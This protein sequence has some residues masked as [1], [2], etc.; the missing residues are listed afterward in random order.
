MRHQTLWVHHQRIYNFT[1]SHLESSPFV[2]KHLPGPLE[3][4]VLTCKL[5]HTP[6]SFSYHQWFFIYTSICIRGMIDVIHNGRQD[7]VDFQRFIFARNGPN[8]LADTFN[9]FK[10]NLFGFIFFFAKN[11]LRV[12]LRPVQ[13][14]SLT[15][16]RLLCDKQLL[17]P[18]L[19]QF[20]DVYFMLSGL[21][22]LS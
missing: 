13:I 19:T 5:T 18:M 12:Q 14:G 17:E 15:T 22:E 16:W 20:T 21:N 7:P 1:N 8:K 2:A 11:F 4:S 9:I 10:E 6:P 3:R